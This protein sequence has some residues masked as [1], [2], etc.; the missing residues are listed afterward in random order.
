[1]S[2]SYW[3]KNEEMLENDLAEKAPWWSSRPVL[4][5]F[6]AVVSIVILSLLWH[7]LLPSK[8]QGN[9]D[10]PYV[11]AE[12]APVKVQPENPGGADIPHK[13]KM[14]YDLISDSGRKTGAE[15][16]LQPA[17]EKPLYDT[18]FE[19]PSE[20]SERRDKIAVE[21]IK[22]AVMQE[23]MV[24]SA[25]EDPVEQ[26][27]ALEEHHVKEE[28]IDKKEVKKKATPA[29]AK[30][31]AGG[32]YRA[33]VAA[34]A[35]QKAAEGQIRALKKKHA[36]LKS[37]S[38]NVIKATVKGKTVYRIQTSGF[39]TRDQAMNLCK[40]IKAEGGQCMLAS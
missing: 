1:M 10:V 15:E 30:A 21:D 18:K 13:D 3:K 32:K 5:I 11:K 22:P 2:D 29:A 20:L 40:K 33:Q 28:V 16:S 6:L 27:V 37:A 17:P 24:E 25:L 38:L 31:K 34:L 8:P 12:N 35:S 19:N 26:P 4:I 39:Q 7:A 14:V 9:V 23:P 36:S